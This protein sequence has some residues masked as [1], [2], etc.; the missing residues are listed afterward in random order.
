MVD[1]KG[2]KCK[3]CEESYPLKVYSFHHLEPEHK[4]FNLSTKRYNSLDTVLN[5]LKKCILVCQNCHAEIHDFMKQ[6]EGYSN[7]IKGNSELWVKN[8][9]RKLEYINDCKCS[10]CGYD[11][12]V[13]SLCIVFPDEYKHY[14]KYNKT[15]WDD[16]FKEALDNAKV[17]CQNCIRTK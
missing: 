5:E 8:K 4:D 7:K 10:D 1:A 9:I 6:K 15:H 2:G 17:L 12:Y 13:G 11:T 3:L 16:D 14:R